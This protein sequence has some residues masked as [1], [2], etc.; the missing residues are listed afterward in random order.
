MAEEGAGSGQVLREASPQK[1]KFPSD[2]KGQQKLN[3]EDDDKHL[4]GDNRC[5]GQGQE[6]AGMFQNMRKAV[7]LQ[8]FLQRSKQLISTP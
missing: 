2:L 5:L 7:Q 3:M 6:A 1:W 4:Q 8:S